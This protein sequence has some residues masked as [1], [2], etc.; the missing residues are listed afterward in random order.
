MDT[1]LKA[2]YAEETE[3][4]IQLS[5]GEYLLGPAEIFVQVYFH[6]L[7]ATGREKR[8]EGGKGERSGRR[9]KGKGGRRGEGKGVWMQ[10]KLLSLIPRPS[11]CPVQWPG[12]E[13][14][15]FYG[16]MLYCATYNIS[17]LD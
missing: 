3:V 9:G 15:S 14:R 10:M 5:L 16:Y 4:L 12:N 7:S 8:R 13:A 6:L 2:L 1:Y 11:H 17:G